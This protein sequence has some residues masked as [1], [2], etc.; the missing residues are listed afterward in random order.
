MADRAMHH[1]NV[2]VAWH[3]SKWSGYVC[4]AP[5]KNT[6]C[7]DLDRIRAERNDA[8]E[9]KV[10]GIHFSE[11]AAAALPPCQGDSGAFMSDKEWCRTF[12]HPYAENQKAQATHGQL[13]TVQ[14][15]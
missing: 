3:D 2:R 7:L 8:A 1:L 15:L 11:L 4:R 13:G 10:A 6:F 12:E 9:D 5:S 14:Q